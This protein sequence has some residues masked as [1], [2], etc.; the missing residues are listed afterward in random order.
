MSDLKTYLAEV[1][2]RLKD[3]ATHATS[4]NEG[5]V[6][7]HE[8]PLLR[9][10][11]TSQADVPTLVAMVRIM[12]KWLPHDVMCGDRRALNVLANDA[13]KKK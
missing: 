6:V 1:E 13:V 8:L 5:R 2:S 10:V 4:F 7:G 3:C 9:A 11:W 12:N